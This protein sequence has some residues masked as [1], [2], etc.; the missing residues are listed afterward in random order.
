MEYILTFDLG[1][2]GN[3]AALTDISGRIIQTCTVPYSVEY[4]QP[5]WV[6]QRGE[7]LIESCRTACRTLMA[8]PDVGPGDIAV[9]G[10]SGTMNGCLPVD[11]AGNAL[12]PNIIHAD[13]RSAQ[14]AKRMQQTGIDWYGLTGNRASVRGTG[15]KV[16]WLKDREPEVYRKTR[17]FLQTKDYVRG[18]FTGDWG[19]TDPSDAA[20][21]GMMDI[22]RRRWAISALAECGIDGNKMPVIRPS[23]SIAGGLTRQAAGM[24]GL[25]TGTPVSVGGG[26]AACAAGG[27][28]IHHPEQGYCCLGSTAWISIMTDQVLDTEAQRLVHHVDLSGVYIMPTGTVQ[29][30]GTSFDWILLALGIENIVQAEELA[31]ALEPGAGGLLFAPY[32]QGE[33][34]PWWDEDVRGAFVGLCPEHTGAH[35]VRAVYEGVA[36]ALRSVLAVFG[37]DAPGQLT[38]LG[39]GVRSELWTRILADITGRTFV[40]SQKPGSATSLGAAQA[41]GVA[42]EIWPDWSS[43]SRI[44][45][46][47]EPVTSDP[48]RFARYQPVYYAFEKLYEAL[49]VLTPALKAVRDI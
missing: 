21:S 16:L 27:A 17:W 1:T 14:E 9:I 40:P 41:A 2:T 35:L 5:G 36:C 31:K 45:A 44:T 49:S 22:G 25:S 7:L 33:R 39:G 48:D 11:A 12:Y 29:S 24:L 26:D 20:L 43:A 38:I 28:G 19:V 47:M 46:F 34:T 8:Q 42:A 13:A 30:A 23:G 10:L 18:F 6:C 15:A 4:P 3:K 32:L 37:K